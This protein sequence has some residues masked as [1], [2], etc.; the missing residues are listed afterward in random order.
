MY[1]IFINIYL[2]TTDGS[3]FVFNPAAAAPRAVP[4]LLLL[5][6][7][8][9]RGRAADDVVAWRINLLWFCDLAASSEEGRIPRFATMSDLPAPIGRWCCL[10][11]PPAPPPSPY[12]PFCRLGK[13]LWV[14]AGP[15]VLPRTF[16]DMPFCPLGSC[17]TGSCLPRSRRRGRWPHD[18]CPHIAAFYL[19]ADNRFL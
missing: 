15:A 8:Q 3:V 18:A 4:L 1:C 7:L 5:G 12:T 11:L 10:V 9:V 16:L 13:R 19:V 17:C 2:V 14:S 6:F